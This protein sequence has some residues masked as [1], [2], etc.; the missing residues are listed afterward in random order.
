MKP[1][2]TDMTEIERALLCC[3]RENRWMF[4]DDGRCDTEFYR[5]A[6]DYVRALLDEV[7]RL[8]NQYAHE[9]GKPQVMTIEIARQ[10][11]R[12]IDVPSMTD[13]YQTNVPNVFYATFGLPLRSEH[14]IQI[15]ALGFVVVDPNSQLRN[16]WMLKWMPPRSD[17]A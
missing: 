9:G 1:T 3:D 4:P 11:I 8:H 15:E 17:E 5:N 6:R 7:R 16:R 14:I 10:W 12:A 13:I 2:A